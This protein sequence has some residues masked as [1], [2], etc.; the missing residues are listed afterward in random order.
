MVAANIKWTGS[1]NVLLQVKTVKNGVE[2]IPWPQNGWVTGTETNIDVLGDRNIYARVNFTGNAGDWSPWSDGNIICM[3]YY[4]KVFLDTDK[5]GSKDATETCYEGIVPIHIDTQLINFNST[6]YCNEYQY[7][8]TDTVPT[9]REVRV[10]VPQHYA[11]TGFSGIDGGSPISGN[12]TSTFVSDAEVNFGFEPPTPTP[13]VMCTVSGESPISGCTRNIPPLVAT[14]GSGADQLQFDV[15]D[16]TGYGTPPSWFCNSD[17]VNSGPY[18]TCSI[19]GSGTYYWGARGRST[20]NAC[21]SPVIPDSHHALTIDQDPPGVPQNRVLG[22]TPDS[23]CLGKYLPRYAWDAVTDTGCAGLHPTPYWAQIST[24]STTDADGGY[25]TVL[26]GWNNSW[27]KSTSIMGSTSYPGNTTLYAHVRSRDVV[28][29]QSAWSTSDSIIIPTPTLFPTIH[30][31]GSFVEDTGG[32]THSCSGTG[33]AVVSNNLNLIF[34]YDPAGGIVPTPICTKTSNSYACDIIID[35]QKTP[36]ATNYQ[37][38]SLNATYP[39]YS[40]VEWRENDTCNNPPEPTIIVDVNPSPGPTT[41]P[42]LGITI[43][44]GPLPG[45]VVGQVYPVI[46]FGEVGGTSPDTWSV[47][48]PTT[49]PPGLTFTSG[50]VL[51][52]TPTTEGIY[53]NITIKV[54]DSANPTHQTAT[55]TYTITI[56]KPPGGTVFTKPLFFHVK[57]WIKTKNVSFISRS[58]GRTNILPITATPYD[59][60]D[61]TADKYF[62]IG[63]S[64]GTLLSNGSFDLGPNSTGISLSGWYSNSG[65]TYIPSSSFT[66]AKFREYIQSRKEYKT[67]NPANPIVNQILKDG[68]YLYQGN[69]SISPSDFAYNTVLIVNG[70]VTINGDV[71]NKFNPGKSVAIVANVIEFNSAVK[72]ASGIFIADKVET[73]ETSDLGLK[74]IGNFIHWSATDVFSND[75]YWED[76]AKPSLFI[77]FDITKYMDLLPYLSTSAYDWKKLQ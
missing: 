30:I 12:T 1:S 49:L 53:R 20:T 19:T 47:V 32:S 63:A 29:N 58:L 8:I 37:A 25:V 27:I 23:Q 64:S 67:I 59:L 66:S 69:A 51:S 17:W 77:V 22:Y 10:T 70:T 26:P 34:Q 4:G 72:E 41:P 18:S 54:E 43:V 71:T 40:A 16:D 76:V 62:I 14:P 52:G 9:T 21:T 38:I 36:C 6:T 55:K 39:G 45:G 46:T 48:D 50:G 5:D 42:G 68:I 7:V 74:I 2:D 61:D 60:I 57:P 11:F 73:G 33:L 15:D 65:A 28:D 3:S 31:A 75:R 13:T 44:N 24:S 35:N 56:V